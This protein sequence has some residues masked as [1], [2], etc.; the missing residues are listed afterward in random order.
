MKTY[1][2]TWKPCKVKWADN[3]YN[4][5][6]LNSDI[7]NF[8]F[9]RKT[10]F[11]FAPQCISSVCVPQAV[12]E[13]CWHRSH[14][15]FGKTI[16]PKSVSRETERKRDR[17]RRKAQDV[18]GFRPFSFGSSPLNIFQHGSLA[19][20]LQTELKPRQ[21][22]SCAKLTS[23]DSQPY[24]ERE[25]DAVCGQIYIQR[26]QPALG[27]ANQQNDSERLEWDTLW[28]TAPPSDRIVQLAVMTTEGNHEE[29]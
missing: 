17:D 18:W 11:L 3:N 19:M 20:C 29:F 13:R 23:L 14:W 15:D 12:D 10:C 24:R 4:N 2:C 7:R 1:G 6:T 22:S 5:K 25:R 21:S 8:Y 28:T 16:L 9:T 27:P 26:V